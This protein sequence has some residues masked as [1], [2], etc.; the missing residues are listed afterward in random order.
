MTQRQTSRS[1]RI[2]SALLVPAVSA[3][4]LSGCFA[5]LKDTRSEIK[6]MSRSAYDGLEEVRPKREVAS[7]LIED[8]TP[9][10]GAQA[11]PAQSGELLPEKL[12]SDD[13]LV[14]TFEE[15]LS[16]EQVA[17][18]IQAAT[19]IRVIV[20]KAD[21]APAGGGGNAG[22]T[23]EGLF[24]PADGMEVT[25]GRMV[26]Q[27]KLSSLLDQISDRFDAEWM[28]TGSNIRISQQVVR[29]FMLHALAGATDVGGS[30]KT[31]SST[32]G[33]LPEQTVDTTSKLSV[34]EEIEKSITTIIGTKA[35][36]SYSPATG[37]ITVA[38]YPSAVKAVENY[39][40][41]QNKL[42][43]RRVK[44]EA[45][46]LSVRLNKQYQN[47]FDVDFIIK[48]AFGNGS[49]PFIFSSLPATGNNIGRDFQAGVI[50]DIPSR[51]NNNNTQVVINALGAVADKVTVEYSGTLV[52]L[53]DQ[54]APLQVAT[55]QAYVAR[56]S[57]TSSD[58]T[59]S[60][61][62]EPATVDIGLSMNML[63]RVIEQDRVMLRIAL[64][65]TDLVNMA[66][67][68]SGGATV[69]LPEIDSTGF[70]QNA[71]MTT[72]ET[73]VLAGFERRNAQDTQT[74]VGHPSNWLMGGGESFE[75]GREIRVLL[76]TA[77]I[78]PED[79]VNVI[80]P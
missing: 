44:L 33:G 75:R 62:L 45:R 18:R 39:L 65:I 9:W 40:L 20:D 68:T 22:N 36:A 14:L 70:L 8:D 47:D 29:T 5:D 26:W 64:G 12:E 23:G 28:Y 54:P 74:G 56:V 34:W 10:F 13:S 24:L 37:T 60:S 71:V 79:P 31:A 77:E 32:D 35:R 49:Q 6:D 76:I 58:T 7:P 73:L 17:A 80:R 59:S 43:L 2:L 3:I 21:A 42:R 63:P 46:V 55:K 4:F 48:E 15:P 38:G 53:S 25:G 41:M 61:T 16:L 52:T 1:F 78:M 11:I 30:V 69:Q 51:F 66:T 72:G 27:G 50:R 57:G 19:N 67:F